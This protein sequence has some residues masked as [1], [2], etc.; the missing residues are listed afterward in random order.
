[1]VAAKFNDFV[2][3]CVRTEGPAWTAAIGPLAYLGLQIASFRSEVSD[4][5]SGGKLFDTPKFCSDVLSRLLDIPK[6]KTQETVATSVEYRNV[7]WDL[8]LVT[9]RLAL[10]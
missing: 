9:T 7:I 10:R 5:V 3:T 2:S 4:P 8:G 6:D 1:M